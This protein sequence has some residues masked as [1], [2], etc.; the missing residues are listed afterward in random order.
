MQNFWLSC[1]CSHGLEVNGSKHGLKPC[2]VYRCEPEWSI[3]IHGSTPLVHLDNVMHLS[4]T[5]WKQRRESGLRL[6][7]F[8]IKFAAPRS[9][10]W[11][12]KTW[13]RRSLLFAQS[14]RTESW[15]VMCR[16]V[17]S[18]VAVREEKSLAMTT[19]LVEYML[20]SSSDR[21]WW[22]SSLVSRGL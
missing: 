8:M 20:G 6:S 19:K 18:K 5:M 12:E 15:S 16:S 21:C 4:P 22:S 14:A 7:L 1:W 2:C 11:S 9:S 10:L 17:Y 13:I 3:I